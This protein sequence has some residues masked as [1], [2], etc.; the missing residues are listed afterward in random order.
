M[1]E[2]SNLLPAATSAAIDQVVT[3]QR[4]LALNDRL[5]HCQRMGERMF[6]A[7]ADAALQYKKE[8]PSASDMM[9]RINTVA[10]NRKPAGYVTFIDRLID[11]WF[12]GSDHGT[13]TNVATLRHIRAT[14]AGHRFADNLLNKPLSSAALSKFKTAALKYGINLDTKAY[15][16]LSKIKRAAKLGH[17]NQTGTDR[18][19]ID[20]IITEDYLGHFKIEKHGNQETIRVR[21]PN[22][23][24]PR[25]AVAWL[26]ALAAEIAEVDAGATQGEKRSNLLL[27]NIG[28]LPQI[29]GDPQNAVNPPIE[30]TYPLEDITSSLPQ[31]LGGSPPLGLTERIAA[32]RADMSPEPNPLHPADYDPLCDL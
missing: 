31:N 20:T 18:L 5:T 12:S 17:L 22:G 6:G 4:T 13:E 15:N 21:L 23:K 28:G 19:V 30:A 2:P 32:L 7:A 24:R 26:R 16:T 1:D 29:P 10:Y 27:C 11:G 9:T 14:F 8:N 25:I 3:K